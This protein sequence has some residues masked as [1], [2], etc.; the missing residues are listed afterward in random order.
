MKASVFSLDQPD[1]E[2][3]PFHLWR[4]RRLSWPSVFYLTNVPLRFRFLP[5]VGYEGLLVVSQPL[6]LGVGVLWLGAGCFFWAHHVLKMN[7]STQLATACDSTSPPLP[8]RSG[9][10]GPEPWP[11]A[12]SYIPHAADGKL[13]LHFLHPPH[14][15]IPSATETGIPPGS[16]PASLFLTLLFLWVYV[17]RSF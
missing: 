3:H 10:G 11:A 9:E 4:G 5:P 12:P 16:F 7:R 8:L 2:V 6:E 13:V 17:R 15:F 14:P 1:G